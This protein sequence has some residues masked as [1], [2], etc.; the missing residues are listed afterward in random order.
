MEKRIEEY[1]VGELARS[2]G[3]S[4]RTLHHY[5]A[6]GL[7][8]P[9]H[10]GAN[11]YRLYGRA[12]AMR[13]QEILFYRAAGMPLADIAALLD[14]SDDPVARLEAHRA[15]LAEG[16]GAQAKMLATLD[17]T[18]AALKGAKPMTIDDLYKPFLPEKQAEYEDWL[19][20]TYGDRMAEAVAAARAREAAEPTVFSGEAVEALRRIEAD[21][22]A[23]YEAGLAPQAADLDA[24]RGWVGEMWG[25]P[26][27]REAHAG[28]AD[29]YLAHPDFIA[30][31]EA[32]APGFSQ[33]LTAAMKAGA[34]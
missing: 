11:G 13:L 9:A 25:Q 20:E 15:R 18:L 29:L 28:L 3:V 19:I 21:L 23:A 12:E 32:L 26:C 6:L 17:R 1:S 33:W 22:V 24:H 8:V 5:D 27:T 7:L 10:V 14:G 34:R 4:V 30:R 16:L 2:S 31:F